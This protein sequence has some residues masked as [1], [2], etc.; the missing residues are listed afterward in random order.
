[1]LFVCMVIIGI[2]VGFNKETA[3]TTPRT[4]VQVYSEAPHSDL[5]P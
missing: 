2:M 1:M 3:V 4:L 5:R